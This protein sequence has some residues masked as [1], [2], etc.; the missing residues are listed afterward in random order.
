MKNSATILGLSLMLSLGAAAVSSAPVVTLSL[1]IAA[2]PFM[3]KSGQDIRVDINITNGSNKP[4][5]LAV[6]NAEGHAEFNYDIQVMRQDKRPVGRTDYGRSL[7]GAGTLSIGF[8]NRLI[9]LK[10]GQS[11]SDY[12]VLNKIYDVSR[13]GVY[14]VQIQQ[15]PVAGT[16]ATARSNSIEVVV[17]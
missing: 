1:S 15:A 7:V 12:F 13:P 14:F 16:N 10:P 11:Q 5:P 6:S 3:V 8:S 2:R 4:M 9:Y 17:Q